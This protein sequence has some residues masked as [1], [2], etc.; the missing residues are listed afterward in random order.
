MI[1]TQKFIFFLTTSYLWILSLLHCAD[2]KECSPSACGAIRNI[3]Y[4]FRL[5]SDPTH[6]GRSE[7]KLTCENN[8]SFINL[9]SIKYYVKAINYQNSTIRL[10]DAS[11][12]N[13]DI[14]FFPV[15][16]SYHEFTG[17]SYSYYFPSHFEELPVYLISCPNPLNNSS[18][19]TD[20]TAW[21]MLIPL[22]ILGAT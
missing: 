3:S 4:P 9:Y 2:A 22:A 5:N 12:N 10:A 13:D 18:L 7:F 6:C 1:T 17:P 21:Y 14:C 19:F 15:T 20:I 16:F 8:V 11:I